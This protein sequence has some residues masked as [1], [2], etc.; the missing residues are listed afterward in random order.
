M[1]PGV[2]DRTVCFHCGGG[3]EHWEV[4]DDA[5]AE[6]ALYFPFCVFVR[7]M[8]GADY[9]HECRRKMSSTKTERGCVFM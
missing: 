1:L 4:T 9:V 6:H 2:C 7:Y 8:K 3:L 5:F